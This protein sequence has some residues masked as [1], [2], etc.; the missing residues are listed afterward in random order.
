MADDGASPHVTRGAR[1]MS[2]ELSGLGERVTGGV[3]SSSVRTLA[4]DGGSL[5]V[6]GMSNP[7][8][9]PF[10]VKVWISLSAQAKRRL[11][12]LHG[13]GHGG[14]WC[15]SPL[16]GTLVRFSVTNSC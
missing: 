4:R 10:L 12:A 5:E 15:S 9:S 16:G 1:V 11:R 13:T 8:K 14:R 2:M 3:V 7:R 6:S